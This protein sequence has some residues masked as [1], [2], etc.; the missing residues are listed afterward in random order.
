M[1]TLSWESEKELSDGE[2]TYLLYKEGKPIKLIARIRNMEKSEVERQILDCRIKYRVYEGASTTE[3]IISNI[4]SFT[5]EERSLLIRELPESQKVKIEEYALSRLYSSDRD[6]CAFYIY[7]LGELKSRRSV[8]SLKPFLKTSSGIIKR[9]VCSALGKIGDIRSEEGLI[10]ALSD[11]R[12]Q[13][14]EY[15][16][17]ALEKIGSSACY[18]RLNTIAQD[19]EERDYVRRAADNALKSIHDRGNGDGDA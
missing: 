6:T 14:R 3:D 7:L 16:I 5:R 17:K 8:P 12:P 10:Y 4:K 19:L 1:D 18:D 11:K 15:A 9:T 13:V 2:V